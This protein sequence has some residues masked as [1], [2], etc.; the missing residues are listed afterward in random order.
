MHNTC[1]FIGGYFAGE[2]L[3]QRLKQ[4]ERFLTKYFPKANANGA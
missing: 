4:I 1:L 2:E 3:E